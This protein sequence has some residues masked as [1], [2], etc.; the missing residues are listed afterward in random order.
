MVEVL[1]AQLG[2]FPSLNLDSNQLDLPPLVDHLL[3]ELLTKQVV[4]LAGLYFSAIRQIDLVYLK[5]IQL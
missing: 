2:L 3:T 4:E 1:F 5:G